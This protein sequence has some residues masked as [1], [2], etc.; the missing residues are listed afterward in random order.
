MGN[1]GAACRTARVNRVP[2]AV[3]A[4][5]VA[6]FVKR[7]ALAAE[8]PASI[9]FLPVL[10]FLSLASY[11][12]P[13][14]VAAAFNLGMP[15]LGLDAQ[16]VPVLTILLLGIVAAVLLARL[17]RAQLQQTLTIEKV[18]FCSLVGIAL[19]LVIGAAQVMLD[20]S[21]PIVQ[22]NINVIRYWVGFL[23]VG[24]LGCLNHSEFRT[25]L[26][27]ICLFYLAVVLYLPLETYLF[28]LQGAVLDATVFDVGLRY[29]ALNPNTLAQVSAMSGVVSLAFVLQSR[30]LRRLG[31]V[32]LVGVSAT[33]GLLTGAKQGLLAWLLGGAVAIIVLGRKRLRRLSIFVAAIVLLSV[34]FAALAERTLFPAALLARYQELL[35]VPSSW[36]SPSYIERVELS[37]DSIEKFYDA[38]ILGNGFGVGAVQILE[39]DPYSGT[40]TVYFVG[41]HNLIIDLLREIGLLGCL[42]FLGSAGGIIYSFFRSLHVTPPEDVHL[43]RAAVAG[44]LTVVATTLMI[45]GGIETAFLPLLLGAMAGA[46]R[47]PFRAVSAYG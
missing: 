16:G 44:A 13:P 42:M 38:P 17:K 24:L 30:G 2:R 37:R 20:A 26:A 35:T 3:T 7:L 10:V 41:S 28:L 23:V 9:W 25:F 33:L 32:I 14:V 15:L 18:A 21:G 5:V 40:S 43:I 45:S 34:V 47:P 8:I 36:E 19:T 6:L 12:S 27:S 46:S 22:H 31:F 11:L 39:T 29:G 1:A 4:A